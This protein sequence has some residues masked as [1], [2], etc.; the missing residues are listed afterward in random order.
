MLTIFFH[1]PLPLPPHYL[2][3]T[4]KTPQSLSRA[5]PNVNVPAVPVKRAVYDQ[6]IFFGDSITQGDGNP[7]LGFSCIDAVR[8]GT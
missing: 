3:M 8:Y 1:P 7:E 2:E 4:K 6:F 5:T